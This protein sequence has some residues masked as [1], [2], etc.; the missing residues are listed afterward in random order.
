[1]KIKLVVAA[2]VFASA[3]SAQHAPTRIALIRSTIDSGSLAKLMDKKCSG[4]ILTIDTS[5]AD[6]LLEATDNNR[7][8]PS[9]TLFSSN[10]DVLFHTSTR[11]YKN[12]MKDVCAFIA[13]KRN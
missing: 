13:K 1:M 4:V 7:G 9:F 8:L 3:V 11:Y 10:G 2:F 12:A 5:K 6:Y